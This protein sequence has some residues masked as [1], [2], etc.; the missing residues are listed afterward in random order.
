MV[1]YNWDMEI[2]WWIFMWQKYKNENPTF[3]CRQDFLPK[4]QEVGSFLPHTWSSSLAGVIEIMG[5]LDSTGNRIIETGNGIILTF[6]WDDYFPVNDFRLWN[7]VKSPILF[8]ILKQFD[9]IKTFHLELD[10]KVLLLHV[11]RM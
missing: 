3:I 8:L 10:S 4:V 11:V 7:F 9:S 6:W 1:D 2:V 5:L